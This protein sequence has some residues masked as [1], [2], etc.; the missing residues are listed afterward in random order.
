MDIVLLKCPHVQNAFLKFTSCNNQALVGC[1]PLA[2]VAVHLNLQSKKIC[3]SSHKMYS[4][5]V[6]NFQDSTTISN[7]CTKNVCELIEYT[8]YLDLD[9]K[10]KTIEIESDVDTNFNRCTWNS[11]QKIDKRNTRFRSQRWSRNH[12]NNSIII[13]GQDT[14]KSP[15]NLLSL[16]L[17]VKILNQCWLETFL[18]E[19][20]NNYNCT[21]SSLC[22]QYQNQSVIK[23]VSPYEIYIE[24]QHLD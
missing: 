20:N 21:C 11:I 7:A 4:N 15:G 1:I 9:R 5:N 3:Q 22:I 6:P 8:T 18:K 10:I 17:H 16:K 19:Y 12:I 23:Y 2:V 24:I 13:I 14:E